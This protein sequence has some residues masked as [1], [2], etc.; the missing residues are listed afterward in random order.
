M[1]PSIISLSMR[2]I[3][4]VRHPGRPRSFD[5][6]KA[7]DRALQ[8]FS[9][10]GYEGASLSD[11]TEAM[12]INRPSLYA[13]FGDKENLFRKALD[14]YTERTMTYMQEA[15]KEKT[16]RRFV[17]CLLRG[18]AE[19]VTDSSHARGCLTVT[20]ALACGDESE[21]IRK[22]LIS[23]R[24]AAERL[25]FERLK[26]AKQEGDLPAESKPVDL[27]R[28]FATVV[29]GIAVQAASGAS[30]AELLRVAETALKVWP[31]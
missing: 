19:A 13:A 31:E 10:K 5:T 8:V 12:G 1:I 20:G 21:P 4:A 14:R 3:T 7:L 15:L 29:Q 17:E 25:I 27:A 23:R 26:R 9:K 18:T 28:Y 30:R 11:L 22:E 2:E 24:R 6:E 16:A